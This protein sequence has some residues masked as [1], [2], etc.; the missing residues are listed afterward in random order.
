MG[1]SMLRGW[2]VFVSLRSYLVNSSGA[3]LACSLQALSPGLPSLLSILSAFLGRCS[4]LGKWFGGT[5]TQQAPVILVTWLPGSSQHQSSLAR[6][7]TSSWS[8][9]TELNKCTSLTSWAGAGNHHESR[10]VTIGVI[11]FLHRPLPPKFHFK[12]F[13]LF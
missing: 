9:I 1:A 3:A 12:L 6:K 13:P 11:Y 8:S 2:D 4:Y 10:I 5:N 7:V